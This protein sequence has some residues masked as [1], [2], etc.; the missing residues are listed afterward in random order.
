MAAVRRF[1]ENYPQH[2]EQL[3]D[4]IDSYRAHPVGFHQ[5]A[6][7]LRAASARALDRD[8]EI[9]DG[10]TADLALLRAS[11]LSLVGSS[12]IARAYALALVNGLVFA[13]AHLRDLALDLTLALDPDLP[14][15]L[16]PDREA[17]RTIAQELADGLRS[18]PMQSKEEEFLE[19][20]ATIIYG[21]VVLWA[22]DP[23][24]EDGDDA[25]PPATVE[26]AVP[27]QVVVAPLRLVASIDP[28][29]LARLQHNVETLLAELSAVALD[30]N[31]PAELSLQAT[32]HAKDG[33]SLLY[34]ANG[35][36]RE[37]PPAPRTMYGWIVDALH[38]ITVARP[39]AEPEARQ[40]VKQIESSHDNE[41]AGLQAGL[42][43]LA[44]SSFVDA[45]I[46]QARHGALKGIGSGTEKLFERVIAHPLRAASATAVFASGVIAAVKNY[47]WLEAGIQALLRLVTR[48]P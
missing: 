42:Q 12:D 16:D 31:T 48:A 22:V 36:P 8:L 26:Q 34:G 28:D 39:P 17:A 14:R 4:Q 20:V 41:P 21:Y 29:D 5:L 7:F 2:P 46:E 3:R 30:D 23:L 25:E 43:Q 18:G 1:Q 10:F 9:N 27:V 44:S 13:Y 6:G 37:L 32:A 35:Q 33:H 11:D 45:A 47:P 38:M 15:E 19:W 40:I 24:D